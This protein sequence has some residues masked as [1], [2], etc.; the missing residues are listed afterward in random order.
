M[1]FVEF[2]AAPLPLTVDILRPVEIRT[3]AH[4]ADQQ[5]ALTASVLPFNRSRC[6]CPNV[7]ARGRYP[8]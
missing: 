7:G 6:F 3:A 2:E 8:P 4:N 5:L 1:V